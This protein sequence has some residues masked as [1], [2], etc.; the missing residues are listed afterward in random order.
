MVAA[1]LA[2]VVLSALLAYR[3]HTHARERADL[4]NRIQAPE[5]V[6]S[7]SILEASERG[8]PDPIPPDL[9][10]WSQPPPDEDDE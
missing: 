8:N 4:L 1:I 10:P 9:G 6:V 7:R 3:E 5:I 2:I